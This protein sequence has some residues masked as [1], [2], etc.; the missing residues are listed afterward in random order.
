MAD[1]QPKTVKV[2]FKAVR[3]PYAGKG[4]HFVAPG[5]Y[6]VTEEKALYLTVT[7]PDDFMLVDQ[8]PAKSGVKEK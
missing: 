6:E 3:G 8:T 7:F 4:V 5:I 1:K 2:E